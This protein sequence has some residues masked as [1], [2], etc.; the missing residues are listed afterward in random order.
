VV[1]EW[2]PRKAD[3]NLRK[4]EVPFSEATTVFLDPLAVTYD[5]PDHS[6]EER[7]FVTIGSSDRRRLLFVAHAEKGD[8]IRIISARR[9]TR[10]ETR[11]YEETPL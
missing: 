8:R 3:E 9:A 10:K 4:H 7:R 2:D 5:D 6:I 11:E 1:F